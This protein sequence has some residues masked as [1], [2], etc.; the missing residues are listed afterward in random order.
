MSFPHITEKKTTR[1]YPLMRPTAVDYALAVGALGGGPGGGGGG[2]ICAS[3]PSRS[4]QYGPGGFP[5]LLGN[6]RVL[7]GS[8]PATA[9]LPAFAVPSGS[10]HCRCCDPTWPLTERYVR[11][12][13]M[14]Y[15]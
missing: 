9:H 12:L 4:R 15:F 2:V 11:A 6:D 5:P 3:G 10:A 14:L 1:L 13:L 7:T 8:N